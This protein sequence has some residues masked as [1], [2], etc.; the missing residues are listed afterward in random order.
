MAITDIFKRKQK[1]SS[2]SNT[3]FG[4]TALGNNVLR[5]AATTPTSAAYQLLYVTTSSTTTAGRTIDMSML[6]RNSTVMACIG[7]KA[8]A[9]AQL[10]IKIM[11]YGEDGT[12]VDATMDKG[13][14][15]R[16][17]AKARSVLSLLQNPNHFQSQYEFWYQFLMWHELAGE[18]FTL[19]WRKDQDQTLQTPLEMYI[20]DST[21][22]TAQLTETRYPAYRLSSPSYGFNKDAELKSHQVL[23]VMDA[24]WQGSG[25][26]NKGILAV[27]LMG[28]DQDIDIY[29]NFVMQNGAKPTG[30]FRTDQVIPDGKFKEI[31]ARLAEAWSSMTGSKSTDLSKPGQSILLDNGMQY[32]TIK[33]LTLQ[34]ADAAALKLQTMKRICGLFGVP[35]SMIGIGDAK[36][37]NTQTMLDE[38]YKSTM[39]P[40]LI[41]IQQKLKGSLLQGYPN[42]CIEFQTENFLKGAPIDQMNYAVAGINAGIMTPNEAREYL[43]KASIDGGDELKSDNKEPTDPISGSSAQDTGGGG[44]TSRVGRTGQAGKA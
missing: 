15:A 44:N 30:L 13:V 23:H 2:E 28:L 19:L 37:N 14:S 11:A 22:I 10:P 3:L 5:N 39:S 27:E 42:L 29:A 24:A 4:Q 36:Y 7:V 25:S 41:N 1:D 9:L 43:G 6:S 16:D 20:L 33:M 18:T 17:K 35:P 12:L 34:D 40:L 31:K 26:F 8:R 21:L 38:F 32:E